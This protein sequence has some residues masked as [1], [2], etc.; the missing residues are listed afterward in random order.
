MLLVLIHTF[1][2]ATYAKLLTIVSHIADTNVSAALV[3]VLFAFLLYSPIIIVDKII[4]SPFILAKRF[5]RR[6]G[7]LVDHRTW[8]VVYDSKTKVPIDPAYV[9]V[10]GRLGTI[11]ATAITD[12]DGRFG[13]IIPQGTYTLTVEKTN[14][15]FPSARLV[16][17]RTDSYYTGLYFGTPFEVTDSE[18]AIA[19]A[20]PMDSV[21]AD[22]NQE[23]KKKR[24]MNSNDRHEFRTAALVYFLVA[25]ILIGVRYIV[26][27]EAF[28]FLVLEIYSVIFAIGLLYSII[29]PAAYYHSVIVD[30]K[31][32]L[33]LGFA[34]I[35][36]YRSG[37]NQQIATKMSSLN[38]QF[39]CLVPNGMYYLT[40]EARNNVGIY[41]LVYTSAPFRVITR[42]INRRFLV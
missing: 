42:S 32:S 7:I 22:W 38:G 36:V 19:F 12:L 3:L 33:P 34:R 35:K 24:H 27:K 29:K 18:R 41:T 25:G 14:Y 21:G 16:G 40:I 1:I 37:S 15:T 8:G 5:M 6:L 23:E 11:V 13:I 20:I 26:Y 30:K 4:A 39:V 2:T 9:V 10:H 31:T 17:K 28:L